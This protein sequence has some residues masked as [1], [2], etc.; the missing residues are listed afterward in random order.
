M[1]LA[2]G[3]PAQHLPAAVQ[4][5]WQAFSGKLGRVMG[6]ETRA[7]AFLRDVIHPD[8]A[9][10]ALG[11]DGRLLGLGGYRTPEAAFAGGTYA[12]LRRHYG[13]FGAFWREAL[14]RQLGED[15]VEPGQFLIDGLCVASDSR[16]QGIGTALVLALCEAGQAMGYGAAR[17]DVVDSNP[18]AQALYA[19]LGF[20]VT[21]SHAIGPL[22]HV[23]GFRRA[24][25]MLRPL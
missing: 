20:A 6:P 25:T 14:L 8:Q 2:H 22:R 3:I 17:I 5:Y 18:G 1:R 10:T 4:L 19:R 11:P 7:M 9:I 15:R 13:G 21:R 12:D 16:G 24:L 23:F